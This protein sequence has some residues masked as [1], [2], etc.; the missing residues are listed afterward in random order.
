MTDITLTDMIV[1]VVK[2]IRDMDVSDVEDAIRDASDLLRHPKGGTSPLAQNRYVV[3]VDYGVVAPRPCRQEWEDHRESRG[4]MTPTG[5]GD[6]FSANS[7]IS[8]PSP[9]ERPWQSRRSR[10]PADRQFDLA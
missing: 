10:L 9:A 3:R 2:M 7:A 4:G 8:P 5:F 6:S 1:R